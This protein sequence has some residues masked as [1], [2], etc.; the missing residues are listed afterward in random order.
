MG[1]WRKGGR[2]ERKAE[3]GEEGKVGGGGR[4]ERN[5]GS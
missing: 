3:G 2:D 1:E 5:F 4:K